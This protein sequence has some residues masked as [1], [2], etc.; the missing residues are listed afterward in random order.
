MTI[1]RIVLDDVNAIPSRRMD[2][3]H[4]WRPVD[5]VASGL[6]PTEP[7]SIGNLVYPG[8]RHLVSGEPEA[9]KTWIALVLCAEEILAGRTALWLDF[10]MGRRQMYERLTA[11]GL[12]DEQIQ[13]GFV[14]LEPDEPLRDDLRAEFEAQVAVTQPSLAVIDSNTP[15]H[16]LHDL[17][18]IKGTDVEAFQRILV[19]PLRAHGAAVLQLDHLTKSKENRGR[20]AI[21]SERKLSV[22]DVHL[23]LE[24][25]GSP[26]AR[27]RTSR[28][29][30]GVHKDRPGHLPR[31]KAVELELRSDGTRVTWK[32]HPMDATQSDTGWRPTIY[33]E[34][35]SLY[36]EGL[37]QPVPRETVVRDVTGRAIYI[38]PAI[39]CL[40]NEHYITRDNDGKLTLNQPFNTRDDNPKSSHHRPHQI[41]PEPSPPSPHG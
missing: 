28:I 33:M 35:V 36:L 30:I 34:R 11:L 14:Y 8:L 23:T 19:A 18:P 38:R 40:I 24:T 39:D 22:C 5:L 16:G 4:S 9:C 3:T 26:F 10:E 20:Y 27:G 1:D 25:I 32:W 41:V 29:K 15:A 6:Q 2:E 12:V 7:P 13:H 21:G 17:D 37:T 31:P